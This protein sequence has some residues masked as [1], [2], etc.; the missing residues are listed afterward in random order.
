MPRCMAAAREHA[1]RTLSTLRSEALVA[2]VA[3][4]NEAG[5]EK[6]TMPGCRRLFAPSALADSAFEQPSRHLSHLLL[7]RLLADALV[8]CVP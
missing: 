8:N 4:L 2:I 7:C 6:V 1:Y 5:R 3:M